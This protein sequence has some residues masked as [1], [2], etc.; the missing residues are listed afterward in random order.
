MAFF[1][2]GQQFRLSF[3]LPSYPWVKTHGYSGDIP[4]YPGCGVLLIDYIVPGKLFIE[5]IEV[6]IYISVISS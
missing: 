5:A 4:L 1:Y 2:L 6:T 3:H